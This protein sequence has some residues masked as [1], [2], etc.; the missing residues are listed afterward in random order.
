MAGSGPSGF[1]GYHI[2]LRGD[3]HKV[4]GDGGT[5]RSMVP[6]AI[7]SVGQ[8]AVADLDC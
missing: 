2:I 1:S 8:V 3:F 7:E 4:P 5:L 6:L